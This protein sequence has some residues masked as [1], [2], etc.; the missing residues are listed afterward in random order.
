[1]HC[2]LCLYR[3]VGVYGTNDDIARS[4][5]QKLRKG[6]IWVGPMNENLFMAEIVKVKRPQVVYHLYNN[7]GK[8]HHNYEY[9]YDTIRHWVVHS[10]AQL[11]STEQKNCL[12]SLW[13]CK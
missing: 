5:T 13:S 2:E 10:K 4:S 1:M 9:S 7:E 6:Q 3:N 8:Q 12:V 11:I